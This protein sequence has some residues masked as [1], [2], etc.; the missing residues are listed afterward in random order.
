MNV[1]NTV[2]PAL[3]HADAGHV[4]IVDEIWKEHHGAN[5]AVIRGVADGIVSFS[6]LPACTSVSELPSEEFLERMWFSG[7]RDHSAHAA[8]PS[9]HA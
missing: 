2:L 4:P 7:E 1:V 5:R 6:W 9:S 8:A 3:A